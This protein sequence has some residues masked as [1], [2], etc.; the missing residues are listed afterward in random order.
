VIVMGV[1]ARNDSVDLAVGA[2]WVL[3]VC[4]TD[5]DGAAAEDTPVITVTLPNGDTDE[6]AVTELASGGYRAEYTVAA[7]GRYVARAVTTSHGAAD[8]TAYATAVVAS[9]AMPNVED[10]RGDQE[11]TFGYL[12]RT[13]ASAGQ[14]QEALDAEAA[15]QRRVC[16]VPAAYGAD[17]RQALMR[18]V[19][20][21]LAMQ[22]IPLAVLQGDAE[23]GSTVPPGSDPEVRRFERPY[24]R[25]VMG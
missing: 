2:V 17:L 22:R 8:L 20:R 10:L 9:A 23:T 15:N 5:A 6:P 4:V 13:S 14:V 18:R 1:K 12:G 19:A 11:T 7:A 24:R 21:N 16:R 3:E 25:L